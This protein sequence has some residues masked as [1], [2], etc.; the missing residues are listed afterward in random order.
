MVV[1]DG[2]AVTA[3][4]R[5]GRYSM[6]SDKYFGTIFISVPGGYD[7]PS[8]GLI[9]C[10]F[11]RLTKPAGKCDTAD[12]TLSK[13]VGNRFKLFVFADLHLTGNAAV[14]DIRQMDST[15]LPDI[16]ENMKDTKGR[17]YAICL[18]DMTTDNKWYVDKF[19]LPEY[20][21]A[22]KS[23]PLPVY[24][25][26]G[27][28]DNDMRPGYDWSSV[29]DPDAF[30]SEAYRKYIGPSYYSF[31]IGK[32][33]FLMLDDII[34]QGP[35]EDENGKVT[36]HFHYGLDS[37]QLKWVERDM[38]FVS[39]GT[40]VI[41][42]LHVP[43]HVNSDVIDGS[44]RVCRSQAEFVKSG[45]KPSGRMAKHEADM[46][47][48]R[49]FEILKPYGKVSILSGH[50]HK[51][52]NIVYEGTIEHNVASVSAVSWMLNGPES[53][54][55]CE[56]GTPGGY[57]IFEADGK[58]LKWVFKACGED[59]PD[60]QMRVY[61]M[62]SV[63]SEYG[64]TS[65]NRILVN[66]FN[67]DPQWTVRVFEKGKELKTKQV[68]AKDPLYSLIRKP[69]LP[70]RP[71]AFLPT[72]SVHMFEAFATTPDGEVEVVVTDRFGNVYRQELARPAAFS[73]DMK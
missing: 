39:H 67:W 37:L 63:P 48:D 40:P 66:V 61:D 26:M 47:F 20:L 46:S 6:E 60:S 72:K 49:L 42:C 65:G 56:D 29:S 73:W 13:A 7:V 51:T 69:R 35:S 9:P 32:F 68:Y 43:M 62:N 41:V 22:M 14:G 23:L 36:Y 70:Q 27:N 24:H 10:H 59:V 28:H 11:A 38:A 64:G 54:I 55:V 3:T 21:D 45:E 57:Q 12:F 15:F 17:K 52:D 8:H 2:V 50:R 25:I 58:N 1:S 30:A 71:K 18:G 44:V 34:A 33:H 19:A 5:Y 4:D 53:R 31:N 16:V